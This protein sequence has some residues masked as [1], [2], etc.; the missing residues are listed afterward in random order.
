MSREYVTYFQ[1]EWL[2]DGQN[3]LESQTLKPNLIG[4]YAI[5]AL[6]YLPWVLVLLLVIGLVLD[7]QPPRFGFPVSSVIKMYYK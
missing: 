5:E 6:T 3:V 7:S 2:R 1:D 4:Q